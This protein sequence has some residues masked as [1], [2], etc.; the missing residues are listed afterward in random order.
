MMPDLNG[1]QICRILQADPR[2]KN[3]PIIFLTAKGEET[4]R[5]SGFETG[6]DDNI[7]K[8]FIINELILRAPSILHRVTKGSSEEV[9]RL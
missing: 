9:K 8:S 5:I 7:C 3:A 6:C 4:D 1:I 2:L